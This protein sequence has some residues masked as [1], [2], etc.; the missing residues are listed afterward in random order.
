MYSKNIQLQ[1]Q[2]TMQQTEKMPTREFCGAR[3]F[4]LTR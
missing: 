2:Y 1:I 4:P 3:F